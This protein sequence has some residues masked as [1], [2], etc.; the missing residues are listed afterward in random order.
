MDYSRKE[1]RPLQ[2]LIR[3]RSKFNIPVGLAHYDMQD[4][5]RKREEEIAN[6]LSENDI[7]IEL[8]VSES[9]RKMRDGKYFFQLFSQGLIDELAE[10]HVRFA[11]GSD[12]HNG[13]NLGQ[14]E[15]GYNF[16]NKYNLEV[17]DLVK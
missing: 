12:S 7:F 1:G 15:E 17:I 5:W 10:R 11:V 14:V 16:I 8:N 4:V 2:E 13:F 6:I 9:G 3:I